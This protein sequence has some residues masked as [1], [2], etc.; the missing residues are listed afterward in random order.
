MQDGH[1]GSKMKALTQC[2]SFP[3]AP[4]YYCVEAACIPREKFIGGFKS[5]GEALPD[6]SWRRPP[7]LKL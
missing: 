1:P 6:N 2:G 4:N 5:R 7:E 3:E